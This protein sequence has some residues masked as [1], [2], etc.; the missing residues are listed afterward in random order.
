MTGREKGPHSGQQEK[1]CVESKI[2]ERED[3]QDTSSL[4]YRTLQDETV[5]DARA[6]ICAK[7]ALNMKRSLFSHS[8]S[9]ILGNC[10]DDTLCLHIPFVSYV[11]LSL[12]FDTLCSLSLSRS[13][14]MR[15]LD[16]VSERAD[17]HSFFSF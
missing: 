6:I 7:D 4:E 3:A 10:Q 15:A 13:L 2:D 12:L 8:L 1:D 5:N 16:V 14:H 9:L 17:Y 11:S